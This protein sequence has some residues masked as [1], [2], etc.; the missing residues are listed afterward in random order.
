[1]F[2]ER[3]LAHSFIHRVE[4]TA[5]RQTRNSESG[6]ILSAV[7]VLLGSKDL[8]YLRDVSAFGRSALRPVAIPF[9]RDDIAAGERGRLYFFGGPG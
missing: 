1:L 6:V 7:P 5:Q 2:L 3:W 4:F 9:A 8:S